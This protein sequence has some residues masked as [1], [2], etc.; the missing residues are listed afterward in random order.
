MR[1]GC[2]V[3]ALLLGGCSGLTGISPDVDYQVM[4][5]AVVN[6]CD[7]PPGNNTDT[8]TAMEIGFT[9]VQA[10]CQVFF[11]EA[12]RA[13]QNAVAANKGLDL[14]L[15]AATA[16]IN[17]TVSAAAAA[18]AITI[19]TAGVVLTKAL[20]DDFNSVYAFNNYLYKVQDHVTTAME[21]YMTKARAKPPANYCMAYTYVQ[22]LAMLCSLSTLKSTLDQQVALPAIN[23]P[24]KPDANVVGQKQPP[25]N[26]SFTRLR[27]AV[28]S[29]SGPPS[30]SYS[31]RPSW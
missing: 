18:K 26:R 6:Q 7:T 20:I 15:V 8:T 19:T 2:V 1:R 22:K 21:D 9:K 13:Q 27:R 14:L 25:G 23:S 29:D 17:P 5:V 31:V 16:I 24:N 10:A 12:T 28:P 11:D 4:V 3:F 30:I